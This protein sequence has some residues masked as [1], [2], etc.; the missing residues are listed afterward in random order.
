MKIKKLRRL[1]VSQNLS[2][3]LTLLQVAINEHK[4]QEQELVRLVRRYQYLIE[5]QE[6]LHN[7]G[8]GKP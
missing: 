4:K 5:E 1:L 2:T 8:R 7:T 6:R 3:A